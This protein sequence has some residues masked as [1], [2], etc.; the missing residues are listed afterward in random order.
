LGKNVKIAV[1][2]GKGG[3]GKTTFCVNLA[4]ALSESGEKVRLLDCDVEEPNDH[5]FVQPRFAV[6]TVVEVQRPVL[7]EDLCTGCGD[8]AAAC[9]YNAIA[10]VKGKVLIFN[11]L[12]HACGLCVLV[13]PEKALRDEPSMIGTVEIAP[14]HE[15]FFF[16]HGTLNV[17]EAMAPAVIR[18]VKSLVDPEAVNIIDASPGTSCPVVETVDGADVAVL[19]TEP[20]PFGLHDL[21]LAVNLTLK[22][23]VATCIVINRSDG[24]DALIDDYAQRVGVPIVGRIPF[25]REYAESYSS[26]AILTHLYPEVRENL[27]RI[28][29]GVSHLAGTVPPPV[30]PEELFAVVERDGAPF[31]PGTSSGHREIAVISGKGG[32]GKTTLI[33]SLALLAE[34]KVL[35]DND[36]D[37]ADLHLLLRPAV[38][39]SHDFAGGMKMSIDPEQCTAC[40]L[41]ADSCRFGAIRPDGPVN[42]LGVE[43]YRIDPFAC[44]GCGVCEYVCP[45]D[46]IMS[47]PNTVGAWYVSGTDHGPMV[48]ARLGIAEENSGRL[49]TQV[50]TV[51]TELARTLGLGL[52]LSDGPPGT[53]CPVIASVDMVL[54]VTEPTVSGVHDMQR[55]LELAAHFG[56]PSLIVVNK[57]DLNAE[58]TRR[59]RTIAADMG[60]RVV[61]E[62]PFDRNVNDA[63]MSCK[64]VIEHGKGPACEA[65]VRLW[66]ELKTIIQKG[67]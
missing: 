21:K 64:T 49:V 8:C 27:L 18:R 11:E 31:A 42:D 62:I 25:R 51:A 3:T 6:Q 2:S 12:C 22:K 50:R 4:Y 57:S 41:C 32:S 56:I 65:I 17:G 47:R 26:G 59:I 39:E 53:G 14:H 20:T 1:A 46:A 23:K 9:R 45:C 63:L 55:V 33:A 7:D 37:A 28:F 54:V 60:A 40:G 10:V 34:D 61:A 44:E 48:H 43:T 52:L 15:P 36:V 16:A 13:C 38:R 5:L 35:A 58:Q 29:A 66:R 30:P 19:V 24:T 67:E